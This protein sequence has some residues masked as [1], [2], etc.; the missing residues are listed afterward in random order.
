MKHNIIWASGLIAVVV[1][2]SFFLRP[3]V[4]QDELVAVET[5][6][7]HPIEIFQG[8]PQ[9]LTIVEAF[10]Q[11]GVEYYPEDIVTVF[12]DPS[13]G[14]GSIITVQ[15]AMPI[16]L[17][18]GKKSYV[19]RT[20][21]NTVKDILSEKKITLGD[22][23]RVS[24]TLATPLQM[25]MTIAI[26]R[27]AR[28]NITETEKIFY[29]TTIEKDYSQFVGTN[30]ILT[31]GKNG[32][33]LNTFLVIREDGEL[34]SKT[35][36]GTVVS[37]G[38]QNARVRQGALNQVTSTCAKYKD[39]VVDASS[40]NGINPNSLFYR[41]LKESSCNPLSVAVAGYQGLLQYNP[42]LWVSLSADAGYSGA[43][44]WSAKSQIYTT[45]WAWANGHRSRWPNP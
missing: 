21:E 10:S 37:V 9:A 39:W 35:L 6:P 11:A 22:D 15:R 42:S 24:P 45:A 5:D 44:I 34:I 13:L 18:D 17:I 40:K 43:S 20:W 29:K 25:N 4:A 19:V 23:D 14:L 8:S 3:A 32:E 1:L 26:T 31:Q 28:T 33:R 38:V 36:I 16:N 30:T 27:V 41:M 2:F 12:P 7:L